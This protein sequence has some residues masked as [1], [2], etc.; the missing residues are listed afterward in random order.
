[1]AWQTIYTAICKVSTYNAKINTNANVTVL[2]WNNSKYL[3]LKQIS[4]SKH[5]YSKY[6]SLRRLTWTSYLCFSHLISLLCW[7]QLFFIF[8][9]RHPS[10]GMYLCMLGW[11]CSNHLV[12]Q[13]LPSLLLVQA[14]VIFRLCHQ[15]NL[16][17]LRLPDKIFTHCQLWTFT[18]FWWLLKALTLKYQ[19][20]NGTAFLVLVIVYFVSCFGSKWLICKLLYRALNGI[21]GNAQNTETFTNVDF[22]YWPM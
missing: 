9:I 14:L 21:L 15:S 1:M 8:S 11:H 22:T 6:P 13:I 5:H 4:Y 20:A 18:G 17:K 12:L 7:W 2:D 3:T 19:A 10:S 16:S